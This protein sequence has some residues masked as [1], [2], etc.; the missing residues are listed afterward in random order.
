V[1]IERHIKKLKRHVES[2]N[3][4]G[5]PNFVHIWL[6]VAAVIAAQ[7]D[8]LLCGLASLHRPLS[9]DE[10][11]DYRVMIDTYIR[12]FHSE[13]VC[14]SQEYLPRLCRR[15]AVNRIAAHFREDIARVDEL[16]GTIMA[17]RERMETLRLSR[18]RVSLQFGKEQIPPYN[19]RVNY[20]EANEWARFAGAVD[21]YLSIVRE[22]GRA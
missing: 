9:P 19:E 6:A 8:R 12:H 21:G 16:S 2:G 20:F 15:Y 4:R 17:Q 3:I 14:L 1:F 18:L 7:L 13:L 10:W 5:I 22:L 11:Y